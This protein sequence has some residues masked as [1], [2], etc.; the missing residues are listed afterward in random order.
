MLIAAKFKSLKDAA[1]LKLVVDACVGLRTELDGMLRLMDCSR[2]TWE[3]VLCYIKRKEFVPLMTVMIALAARLFRC[4]AVLALA[5]H[6]AWAAVASKTKLLPAATQ[7]V[8]VTWIFCK[9]EEGSKEGVRFILSAPINCHLLTSSP[10]PILS[11]VLVGARGPLTPLATAETSKLA[12]GRTV[13]MGGADAGAGAQE[14]GGIEPPFPGP[15]TAR[16]HGVTD[17]ASPPTATGNG[18]SSS[19]S[20]SNCAMELEDLGEVVGGSLSASSAPKKGKNKNKNKNKLPLPHP[21]LAAAVDEMVPLSVKTTKKNVLQSAAL[22]GPGTADLDPATTTT[23][24]T[25]MM[26]KKKKKRKRDRDE[27]DE[28][29]DLFRGLV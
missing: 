20:S 22:S 15:A 12:L 17:A 8:L 7:E 29:D 16:L 18:S 13:L 24:T 25:T 28:I 10:I 14:E 19:S 26:K 6:G 23:T 3:L 27:E 2:K 1:E 11:Q 21:D 9:L 4:A 5:L